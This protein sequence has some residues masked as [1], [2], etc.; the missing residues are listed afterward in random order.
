MAKLDKLG[1]IDMYAVSVVMTWH[2]WVEGFLDWSQLPHAPDQDKPSSWMT[3]AVF[4]LGE[5]CADKSNYSS[6]RGNITIMDYLEFFSEKILGRQ[7]QAFFFFRS[8]TALN[9]D[10]WSCGSKG[11]CFS[12]SCSS[13]EMFLEM[14]KFIM[15][16]DGEWQFKMFLRNVNRTLISHFNTN[17][18]PIIFFL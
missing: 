1:S 17:N 16:I 12:S 10:H 8:L 13:E 3:S 14:Q 15:A 6:L 11:I 2:H 18:M 9:N 5:G 4:W 7:R